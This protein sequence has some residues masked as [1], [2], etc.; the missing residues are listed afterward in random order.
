MVAKKLK[1]NEAMLG[2]Q[3]QM[4]AKLTVSRRTLTHPSSIGDVAE[5]EWISLLS[6][7]LPKRYCAEKGFVVDHKGNVSDQI[8]ILIYDK[9][10]TPFILHMN[11]VKYIP[12]EA[13]YAAI[14]CKQDI[15]LADIAYASKK[16][17]SVRRLVRTSIPIVH[18]GGEFRPKKPHNILCG[19]I[20]VGGNMSL[21]AHNT[22]ERFSDSACLN[23]VCSLSGMYAR[24]E[25]FE[26]WSKHKRPFRLNKSTTNLSLVKFIL[27]LVAD[28]QAIGTV[29]AIDVRKYLSSL[30]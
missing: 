4:A 6:E 24:L 29:P 14:E 21:K 23:F 9:H 16:A 3:E 18:A 12:S 20:C 11:G 8:D 15:S 19:L 17:Q 10:Y 7:Y 27:E 1:L 28:L 5:L 25:G 26:L 22:L 2:L 13:I 30:K